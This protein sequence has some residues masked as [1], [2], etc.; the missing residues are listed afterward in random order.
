[1]PQKKP[2]NVSGFFEIPVSLVKR[3]LE[4]F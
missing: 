2:L 3:E 1:M 4:V